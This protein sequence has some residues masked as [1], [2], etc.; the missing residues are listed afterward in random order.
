MVDNLWASLRF[1][2]LST[3]VSDI[4]RRYKDQYRR[5]KLGNH[6]EDTSCACC[7]AAMTGPGVLVMDAGQTFE[8]MPVEV[9]VDS[10]KKLCGDA[11]RRVR[12]GS[13]H[14]RRQVQAR[15]GFGGFLKDVHADRDVFMFDAILK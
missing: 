15:A 4:R 8:A 11:K 14:V 5:P 3:A 12:A 7:S 13:V 1:K 6:C 10:I 9:I 2:C